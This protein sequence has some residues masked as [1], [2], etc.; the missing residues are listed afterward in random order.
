M[1]K[2]TITLFTALLLMPLARLHAADG[3]L[4]EQGRSRRKSSSRKLLPARSRLAAAELQMYLER[5]SG[6]RLEIVTSPTGAMPV[7]IYVGESEHARRAGVDAEDLGRDAFR[8]VS[9]PDWLALVGRDWDFTPV[10]PWARS[11][12]DWLKNKQ[13]E[14]MKSGRAPVAESGRRLALQRLQQAA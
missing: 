10:E 2:H 12:T 6:S 11:H 7:K 14:W 1:M 13:A 4:V 8:M 9:G 5:I 3:F